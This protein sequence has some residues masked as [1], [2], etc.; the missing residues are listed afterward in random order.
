M[1]VEVKMTE[2]KIEWAIVEREG[3]GYLEAYPSLT[4]GAVVK[5]CVGMTEV[6]SLSFKLDRDEAVEF[7]KALMAL[8]SQGE[9]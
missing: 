2:P 6:P 9:E 7:G 4:G 5:V 3:G 1:A 8:G